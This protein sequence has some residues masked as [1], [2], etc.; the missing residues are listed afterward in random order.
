M[1]PFG[2]TFDSRYRR[3][4]EA[5]RRIW[6]QA[7]THRLKLLPGLT[8]EVVSEAIIEPLLG[9]REVSVSCRGRTHRFTLRE[10]GTVGDVGVAPA[11]QSLP[12][13]V[14]D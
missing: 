8:I 13:S 12:A 1:R 9:V 11:F 10:T 6:R 3:D 14:Q 7:G 5:A 4:W 2:A